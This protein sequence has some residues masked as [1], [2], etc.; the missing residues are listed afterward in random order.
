MTDES[1]LL[2]L[3]EAEKVLRNAMVLEIKAGLALKKIRDNELYL[4]KGFKTFN[5]YARDEWD[6]TPTEAAK[7]ISTAETAVAHG[8]VAAQAQAELAAGPPAD[9]PTP[10]FITIAPDPDADTPNKETNQ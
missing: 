8:P 10:V 7:L 5:K 6:M 2:R 9:P 4:D 1:K 3:R